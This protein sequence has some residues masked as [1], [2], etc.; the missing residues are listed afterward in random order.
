MVL[1]L[2]GVHVQNSEST[3]RPYTSPKVNRKRVTE[4]SIKDE[5]MKCPEDNTETAG[6]FGL[7][8]DSEIQLH[9]P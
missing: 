8:D 9:N 7:G 5:S 6:D 1:E 4:L 2:L 3:P